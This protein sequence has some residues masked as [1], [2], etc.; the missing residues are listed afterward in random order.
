MV[1]CS[2]RSPEIGG[3]GVLLL[4]AVLGGGCGRVGFTPLDPDAALPALA[5]GGGSP[6][7][8]GGQISGSDGGPEDAGPDALFCDEA[9][10]CFRFEGET[11]GLEITGATV[12][13]GRIGFG[14]DRDANSDAI[15]PTLETVRFTGGS[16][17]ELFARVDALPA[18]GRVALIDKQGQMGIFVLPGGVLTCRTSSLDLVCDGD[19]VAEGEWFHAAC[20]HGPGEAVLYR[21]GV[22]CDTIASSGPN[23]GAEALRLGEDSPDGGDELTGGLDEVRVFAAARTAAEVAEAAA[24]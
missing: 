13:P 11:S 14:L 2:R 7:D 19:P 18:S 24:R 17:M 20:T 16:S 12:A 22:P 5:D 8:G 3:P 10:A 4:L 23:D 6:V 9:V 21:D 15:G 1:R